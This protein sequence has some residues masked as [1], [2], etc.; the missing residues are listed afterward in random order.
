MN[1]DTEDATTNTSGPVAR[2]P[3]ALPF[4]RVPNDGADCTDPP[5]PKKEDPGS[6]R[7]TRSDATP[8]DP[9][10]AQM[11]EVTQRLKELCDRYIPTGE[12][13]RRGFIAEMDPANR[14]SW[15]ANALQDLPTQLYVVGF[16]R[17]GE[18]SSPQKTAAVLGLHGLPEAEL[19]ELHAWLQCFRVIYVADYR[20]A[21]LEAVSIGR[22]PGDPSVIDPYLGGLNIFESQT[23]MI[24]RKLGY[25]PDIAHMAAKGELESQRPQVGGTVGKFLKKLFG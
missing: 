13:A 19:A 20:D 15:L 22:N 14:P 7:E 6:T 5:D 4:I 3:K 12:H 8:D 17:A 21:I 16:L 11:R 10:L 2:Q 9:R 18:D 23:Y 24:Y 25:P 1:G